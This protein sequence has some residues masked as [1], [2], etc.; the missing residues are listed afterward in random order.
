MRGRAR[1]HRRARPRRARRPHRRRGLRAA[2]RVH[3]R[4][5][6]VLRPAGVHHAALDR[7]EGLSRRRRR[8][9]LARRL[10]RRLL[11]HGGQR[12]SRRRQRPWATSRA[13]RAGCGA[14]ARSRRSCAGCASTTRLAA[15]LAST[16][17]PSSRRQASIA[18][19]NGPSAAAFPRCTCERRPLDLA[20]RRPE[21]EPVAVAERDQLHSQLRRRHMVA[22]EPAHH[23]ELRPHI[24]RAE[25]PER[26]LQLRHAPQRLC[27]ERLGLRGIATYPRRDE[28]V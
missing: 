6:R 27:A 25:R 10:P 7:G 17:S 19:S 8:G 18:S 21:L 14:T 11:A 28:H 12:R 3:A 24:A 9:R 16:A 22:L 15:A 4:H 23:R 2:R 26:E 13:F 1:V 20:G 5:E